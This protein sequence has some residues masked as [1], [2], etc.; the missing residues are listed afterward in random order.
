MDIADNDGMSPFYIACLSGHIDVVQYL[1]TTTGV[2]IDETPKSGLTPLYVA[3]REGHLDVV[4]YLL[5]RGADV[6]TTTASI[7]GTSDSPPLFYLACDRTNLVI[8]SHLIEAG[9]DVDVGNPHGLAPFSIAAS[10][11]NDEIAKFL[12]KHYPEVVLKHIHQIMSLATTEPRTILF[13][14]QCLD[15]VFSQHNQSPKSTGS[16]S[17]KDPTGLIKLTSVFVCSGG[18]QSLCALAE[19]DIGPQT[20]SEGNSDFGVAPSAVYANIPRYASKLKDDVRKFDMFG[21][22]SSGNWALVTALSPFG[23]ALFD[24]N[25]LMPVSVAME[26]A[27]PAEVVKALLKHD[28]VVAI[29]SMCALLNEDVTSQA[30]KLWEFAFQVRMFGMKSLRRIFA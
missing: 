22:C 17:L 24:H 20:L 18:L 29:P 7:S 15:R 28:P 11:G 1:I 19:S 2:Q 3:T 9:I 14:L 8:V 10:R 12:V 16:S 23:S 21:A 4:K 30:K 26:N 5:Q 25:G 6:T 13:A 27:A